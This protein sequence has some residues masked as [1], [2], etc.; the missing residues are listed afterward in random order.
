MY[1]CKISTKRCSVCRISFMSSVAVNTSEYT[2]C[3]NET[4]KKL[5]KSMISESVCATIN[6]S[7]YI[8]KAVKVIVTETNRH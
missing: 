1:C 7:T 2:L 6:V 4:M 5:E 3:N 8:V